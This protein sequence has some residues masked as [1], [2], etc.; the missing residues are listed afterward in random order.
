MRLNVEQHSRA[1]ALI[2]YHIDTSTIELFYID[3]G[4]N[5]GYCTFYLELLCKHNVKLDL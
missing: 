3:K 4:Q 2:H 1:A 5:I